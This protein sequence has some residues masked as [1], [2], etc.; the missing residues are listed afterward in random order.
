MSMTDPVVS[1]AQ[2]KELLR[3]AVLTLA[4]VPDPDLRYRLGAKNG[5]PAYIRETRDAYGSAPPRYRAFHP[6]SRDLTM[7]LDMLGMLGWYE[8]EWGSETVRL[9]RAWVFGASLWQLQ[10]RCSTNRRVPASPNT[11]HRRIDGMVRAIME[12]FAETLFLYALDELH[13]MDDIHAGNRDDGKVA[14]DVRDLPKSSKNWTAP[15]QV[16]SAAEKIAARKA[17]DKHLRKNK[18]RALDRQ[19]KAARSA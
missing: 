2:V 10:E 1:H 7:F 8:R 17:L 14:S 11:V 16:I 13:E 3:R 4:A 6:T 5:W 12:E 19:Q 15:P 9:F 18:S